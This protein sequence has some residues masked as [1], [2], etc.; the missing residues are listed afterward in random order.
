[1]DSY[2]SGTVLYSLPNFSE[3]T[4]ELIVKAWDLFSNATADTIRFIVPQTQKLLIR[5]FS[6]FPNPFNSLTQFS[7]EH[8]QAAT[9]LSVVLDIYDYNGLKI[10]SKSIQSLFLSNRVVLNWS[11]LTTGGNRILPGIYYCRLTVSDAKLTTSLT[12]KVLKY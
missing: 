3:G 1:M 9:P 6:I 10:Y 4:H 5:N 7:F 11:G 12:R 2:Q 8:N